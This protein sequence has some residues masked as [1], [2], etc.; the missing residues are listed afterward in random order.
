VSLRSNL[1]REMA[2]EERLGGGFKK[3]INT[4]VSD[5]RR[6]KRYEI[7][8]GGGGGM[9]SS[10]L[11]VREKMKNKGGGENNQKNKTKRQKKWCQWW[12]LHSS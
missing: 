10:G 1:S 7:R 9:S 12:G 6:G 5:G 4:K 3:G 11:R 8:L 2:E